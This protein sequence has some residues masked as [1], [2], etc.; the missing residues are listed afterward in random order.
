[1]LCKVSNPLPSKSI[2]IAL[3][4]GLKI[5]NDDRRKDVIPRRSIS[6]AWFRQG[7]RQK[8]FFSNDTV[9]VQVRRWITDDDEVVMLPSRLIS[10]VPYMS[11][12]R[13]LGREMSFSN[14]WKRDMLGLKTGTPIS[15]STS[16]LSRS[17]PQRVERQG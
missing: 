16:V 2:S 1:M 12:F 4:K 15:Q 9:S 14:I 11:V 13:I 8:Q 7:D 10:V 5:Q 17:R 3:L 6:S